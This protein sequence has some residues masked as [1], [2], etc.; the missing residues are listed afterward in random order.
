MPVTSAKA[1]MSLACTRA[2]SSSRCSADQAG[3]ACTVQRSTTLRPGLDDSR[4]S[5][6]MRW[7]VLRAAFHCGPSVVR[8]GRTACGVQH[9]HGIGAPALADAGHGV[10]GAG[11]TRV[12]H[13]EVLGT[14]IKVAK[15]GVD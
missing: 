4:A 11:K 2:S 15:R 10:D 9:L 12:A 8:P 3:L 14:R 13:G 1:L 6:A 5:Q 7:C